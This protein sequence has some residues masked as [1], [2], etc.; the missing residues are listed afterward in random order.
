MDAI[1][2]EFLQIINS[3]PECL[4][5]RPTLRGLLFD[6]C[7]TRKKEINLIIDAYE[8]GIIERLRKSVDYKLTV[9][10]LRSTLLS[11]YSLTEE[12][13]TWAVVSWCVFLN[14]P[15]AEKYANTLYRTNTVKSPTG[16]G[17]YETAKDYF[18]SKGC[19]IV[20]KRPSGGCLWVI[21][22]ESEIKKYVE[23]AKRLFKL[24][25][26]Y[27]GGGRATSYKPGWFTKDEG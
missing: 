11:D 5:S 6:N 20:D 7:P 3:T 24:S 16:R 27:C 12:A 25:G 15:Q 8:I 1:Q 13:A 10:S 4:R 19:K 23:E 18:L 14:L 21:G 17:Q 9:E 22:K 2:K 26:D